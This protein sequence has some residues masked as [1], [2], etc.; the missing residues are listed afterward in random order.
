MCQDV[1]SKQELGRTVGIKE[2]RNITHLKPFT[3]K[4]KHFK[5]CPGQTT[6]YLQASFYLKVTILQLFFQLEGL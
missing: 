4:L 6:I 3:S 2:L 5:A 1:G